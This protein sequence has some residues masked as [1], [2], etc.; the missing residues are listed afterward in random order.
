MFQKKKIEEPPSPTKRT[1]VVPIQD[2][3]K[4]VLTLEELGALEITKED[5]RRLH[6]KKETLKD[7]NLVEY[8][9]Y[10]SSSYGKLAN[11]FFENFSEY[12]ISQF[13][14]LYTTLKLSL[15]KSDIKLLSKTY[16]SVMF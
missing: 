4:E 1:I 6:K 14:N 12:F 15:V 2:K 9:L 7:I 11:I 3:K 13:K 10:E 5:I 8:T 16:V